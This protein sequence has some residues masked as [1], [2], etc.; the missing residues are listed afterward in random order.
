MLFHSSKKPVEL[1]VTHLNK[2]QTQAQKRFE[3]IIESSDDKKGGLCQKLCFFKRNRQTKSKQEGKDKQVHTSVLYVLDYAGDIKAS[4]T[5]K[6]REEISTIISVAKENDEVLIRLES[7]GGQV[8]GYGLAAAQLARLKDA[9]IR[10][11]VAVDKVAASGG[12]MM[13]CVSD[14]L[15][16]A[17]FA[18]IGSI[19]V[20]SQMPNFHDFLKKH[21][22]D[23]EIF[24]A[25]EY[26]RTVT[27][28]GKNDEEDRKKYQSELERIHQLFKNHVMTYRPN[29]DIEKIATGE[30]WF[31]TD[32]Q[33]LGLIDEKGTSD[34]FLMKKMNT[35]TVLH[36]HSRHKLGALEKLGLVESGQDM[37]VQTMQLLKDTVQ[38]GVLSLKNNRTMF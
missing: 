2:K 38:T 11:T 6:L 22:I 36:L 4:A 9:G 21:D 24:T 14:Y 25:G 28:F 1:V 13:A 37:V 31:A 20:V 8:H 19:G 17:P 18:I 15:I 29:L 35:H 27:M 32:A 33:T 10:L 34:E 16:A 3:A 23:V 7:A 12:Y 26:K 5:D 30:F